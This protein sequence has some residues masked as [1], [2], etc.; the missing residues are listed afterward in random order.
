MRFHLLL[1]T[2]TIKRRFYSEDETKR[3]YRE[4]KIEEQF[5]QHR[6]QIYRRYFM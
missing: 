5:Q 1:I 2:V 3:A 6:D 4:Q